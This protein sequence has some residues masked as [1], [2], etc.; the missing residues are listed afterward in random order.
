MVV[1]G[2]PSTSA[3]DTPAIGSAVSSLT[4]CAP[5]TVLT[6]ASF[7]GLTVIATVSMSCAVPS[8]V[9]TVSVSEPLKLEL[10]V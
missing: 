3:T 2:V 10:P 9:E 4:T 5:G 6:G 1:S 7:T 8:P